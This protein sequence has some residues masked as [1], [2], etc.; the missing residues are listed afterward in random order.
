MQQVRQV[1]RTKADVIITNEGRPAIQL[2][3]EM[4]GVVRLSDILGMPMIGPL[5]L[6]G[7]PISLVIISYGAGQ[8][9][10]LVDEVIHVQ[11]I[12]VRPLGSQ[13]RRVRRITGAAILGDGTLAIVLDPPEL[14]Q[15]S[16]RTGN[17]PVPAS[18]TSNAIPGVLVVE[19]SVTSRAFLQML[20]EREGYRVMTAIDG[21]EAFA[22]LKEHKLDIIVSDVDMPRMN[23][24]VL[25]EKIRSDTRLRN[26]PIVLVTSLDSAEDQNHGVAV[27]ADAYIVKSSF[28]KSALLK[29]IR[30]LI[31]TG[32][33]PGPGRKDGK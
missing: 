10:C 9:A 17:L 4:I 26:I 22:I 28:E 16:L 18:G 8:I 2:D 1:L 19:D 6:S 32:R 15:E 33:T 13:L 27:G 12:V 23:G 25:T 29:V 24:F 3:N 21:M 7:T 14:I 20:L 5:P 31:K 30:S 11:E